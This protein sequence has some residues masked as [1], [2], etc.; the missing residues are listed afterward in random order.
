[1]RR[2]LLAALALMLL[3]ACARPDAGTDPIAEASAIAD[4]YVAGYYDEYP[5]DAYETGYPAPLDRMGDYSLTNIEA[6]EARE[7]GT[8]TLPMLKA[9]IE[10]WI[11]AVTSCLRSH[12]G[13]A[14]WHQLTPMYARFG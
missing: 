8:V 14:D 7:D 3:A 5:E 6:W 9:K 13:I 10:A 2:S 12:L 4:E 11:E 1:M